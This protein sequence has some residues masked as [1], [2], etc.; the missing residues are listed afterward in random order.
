M[1][2]EQLTKSRRVQF[3]ILLL[4]ALAMGP[5]V[6]VLGGDSV[7][8]PLGC[9]TIPDG[10]PSCVS[11]SGQIYC[12]NP[13]VGFLAGTCNDDGNDCTETGVWNCGI[14]IT[15]R[16][17]WPTGQPCGTQFICK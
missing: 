13:I 8:G 11:T 15:C 5:V 10:C 16:D 3:M 14:A 9:R 4:A 12:S 1:S 2:L 6:L 17:D 7:A